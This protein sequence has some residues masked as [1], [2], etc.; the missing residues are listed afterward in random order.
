MH[1]ENKQ[2]NKTKP[3]IGT[4]TTGLS[5]TDFFNLRLISAIIMK[6]S[7]FKN[8]LCML[9][10]AVLPSYVTGYVVSLVP[11]AFLQWGTADADMKVS[12]VKSREPVKVVSL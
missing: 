11:A 5:D 6:A 1:W 3:H 12:P 10:V 8:V 9:P 4:K 2:T 7:H